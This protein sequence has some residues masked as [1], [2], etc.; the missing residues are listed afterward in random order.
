M[1]I[2]IR[3]FGVSAQITHPMGQQRIRLQEVV[4]S[5]QSNWLLPR[6]LRFEARMRIVHIV[7]RWCHPVQSAVVVAV[8][9]LKKEGKYL[10]SIFQNDVL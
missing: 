5:G 8:G 3:E 9:P 6:S 1:N 4:T 7:T 2:H 10:L